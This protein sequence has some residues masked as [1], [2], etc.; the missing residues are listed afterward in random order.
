LSTHQVPLPDQVGPRTVGARPHVLKAAA[1]VSA[2]VAFAADDVDGAGGV[3]HGRVG[4]SRFPRRVGRAARPGDTCG[5]RA[6]ARPVAPNRNHARAAERLTPQIAAVPREYARRRSA[7]ARALHTRARVCYTRAKTQSDGNA[8]THAH[9]LTE[10][11]MHAQ[12]CAHAP[13]RAHLTQARLSHAYA[14]PARMHTNEYKHT[15]ESTYTTDASATRRYRVGTA[16][17]L[18]CSA[19]YRLSASQFVA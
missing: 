3:D 16:S 14:H 13:V 11:R 10:A 19:E 17:A 2:V 5:R 7:P 12:T 15:N 9:A 18:R 6:R 8:R 4:S 1:I